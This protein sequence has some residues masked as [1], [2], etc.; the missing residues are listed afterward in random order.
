MLARDVLASRG[1]NHCE[2]RD[3]FDPATLEP[4]GPACGQPATQVILWRDRRYSPACAEHGVAA[5]DPEAR[6]LVQGVRTL[7]A[8]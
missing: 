2:F 5:L 7:A 1:M 4:V 8:P 6:A 3:A